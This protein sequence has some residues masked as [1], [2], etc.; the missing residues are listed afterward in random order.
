[1]NP[2]Y[3]LQ[4]SHGWTRIGLVINTFFIFTMVPSIFFAIKWYGPVG[5]AFVWVL[6]N[7]IYMAFGVPITH[8]RLLKGEASQW[9]TRDVGFPLLGAVL[10]PG[11]GRL[12]LN[13]PLQSIPSITAI[14]MLLLVSTTMAALT[15]PAIREWISGF[16]TPASPTNDNRPSR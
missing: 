6:L 10:V 3:A 12:L 1:M 15:S 9:F 5:A 2:P 8:R 14:F 16:R 13:R 11:L 7:G 4:L